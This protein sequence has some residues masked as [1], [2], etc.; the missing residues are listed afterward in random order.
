MDSFIIYPVGFIFGLVIG[1]FLNVVIFRTEKDEKLTGRSRCPKCKKQIPWYDNVPILSFLLLG[2]RCRFCRRTISAQYPLVELLTGLT[3]LA[4]TCLVTGNILN[5]WLGHYFGIA[6]LLTLSN[7]L[8]ISTPLLSSDFYL[9][10]GET[11][12][13][14]AIFSV[15]IA[16]LVYDL[17]HM[18]IPDSFSFAG[19][20]VTVFYALIMDILLA[21]SW[22]APRNQNIILDVASWEKKDAAA[23]V[24]P[25]NISSF[26]GLSSPGFYE[27]IIHLKSF[28]PVSPNL[29]TAAAGSYAE[30]PWQFI[31]SIFSSTH[32]GSGI[33]AGLAAAAVF[34]LIVYLSQETWM[35]MGDVKL[36]FFLG[37]LLGIFKTTV[38]TF[39]A[40]ELGALVGIYLI[41]SGRAKMKTALPFGPFLIIGAVLSLLFS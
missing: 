33:I 32:L 6:G 8:N 23:S 36:V 40:F 11:F 37:L 21:I 19:S 20:A 26:F 14:W 28:L 34:F 3:F 29:I 18:L 24:F 27:N 12:F 30:R 16:I 10:T 17:K 31:Y 9:K 22:L 35:G 1:S 7:S 41:L 5:E 4:V 13:L 39:L 2:G 15:F 38:G 25:I